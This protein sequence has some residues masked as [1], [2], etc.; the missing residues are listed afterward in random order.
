MSEAEIIELVKPGANGKYQADVMAQAV[1]RLHTDM[2]Q[3]A[4]EN[5]ELKK[6]LGKITVPAAQNGLPPDVFDEI[7]RVRRTPEWRKLCEDG[8]YCRDLE[9]PSKE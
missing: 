4:K 1:N 9:S 2:L 5:R 8:S 3:L 7:D 6:A